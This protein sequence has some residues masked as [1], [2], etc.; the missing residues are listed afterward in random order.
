[1]DKVDEVKDF[2][3]FLRDRY[4]TDGLLDESDEWSDDDM[5]D[6]SVAS[7]SYAFGDDDAK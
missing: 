7:I 4:R 1:M 3:L 5:H 6:V 2:A